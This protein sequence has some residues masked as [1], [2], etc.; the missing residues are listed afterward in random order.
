MCRAADTC[1]SCRRAPE[2][3]RNP[4]RGRKR[5]AVETP[6]PRRRNGW[7]GSAIRSPTPRHRPCEVD[8]RT[9]AGQLGGWRFHAAARWPSRQRMIVVEADGKYQRCADNGLRRTSADLTMI[10]RDRHATGDGRRRRRAVAA[11]PVSARFALHAK[12]CLK[13]AVLA[14][15]LPSGRASALRFPAQQGVKKAGAVGMLACTIGAFR[16]RERMS[17]QLPVVTRF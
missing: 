6:E 9:D 5:S 1:S 7:G 17:V 3:D 16:E 8:T 10:G 15:Q 4:R 13:P 12:Q 11:A 2:P 14:L